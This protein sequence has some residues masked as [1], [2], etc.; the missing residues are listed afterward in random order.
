MTE[1]IDEVRKREFLRR[2]GMYRDANRGKKAAAECGRGRTVDV[3]RGLSRPRRQPTALRT[4]ADVTS[5]TDRISIIPD[6][7]HD[8]ALLANSRIVLVS[9]E[10]LRWPDHD[11]AVLVEREIRYRVV[12][13]ASSTTSHACV[14]VSDL[15]P[16]QFLAALSTHLLADTA[17]TCRGPRATSTT[18]LGSAKPG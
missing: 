7:F 5:P 17:R 4:A 16:R 14:E 10:P 8:A 13:K 15:F 2:G 18:V 12:N 9:F 6:H 11:L 1:A 3:Q